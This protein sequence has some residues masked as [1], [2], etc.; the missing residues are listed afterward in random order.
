[1]CKVG[2]IHEDDGGQILA[3]QLNSTILHSSG[4]KK[5]KL[6]KITTMPS[7][8]FEREECKS[9]RKKAYLSERVSANKYE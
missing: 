9:N 2:K 8:C 6:Q 5:E 3:S 1:M 7:L 4:L